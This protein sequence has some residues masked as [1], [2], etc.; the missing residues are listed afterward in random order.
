MLTQNRGGGESSTN[1]TAEQFGGLALYDIFCRGPKLDKQELVSICRDYYAGD[2]CYLKILD[3][4]TRDYKPSCA[5]WWYTKEPLIYSLL[6]KALRAFDRH[7]ISLF[8]FFIRDMRQALAK[9]HSTSGL[10]EPLRLYRGQTMQRDEITY[11]S[12]RVGEHVTMRAFLSTTDRMVAL[13][14]ASQPGNQPNAHLLEPVLLEI[15]ADPSMS[16]LTPFANIQSRSNHPDEEEWLFHLNPI[17]TL[18]DIE[19]NDDFT[20]PTVIRLTLTRI[21]EYLLTPLNQIA[22]VMGKESICSFSTG[23]VALTDYLH[24]TD[25]Q[26]QERKHFQALCEAEASAEKGMLFVKLGNEAFNNGHFALAIEC[27]RAAIHSPDYSLS[28]EVLKSSW[29]KIGYAHVQLEQID[30]AIDAYRRTLDICAFDE[31]YAESIWLATW[32]RRWL[33]I[34][35]TSQ[36]QCHEAI[37]LIRDNM[38]ITEVGGDNT[39]EFK[40]IDWQLCHLDR[41]VF[42]YSTFP[43]DQEWLFMVYNVLADAYTTLHEYSRARI[44]LQRALD[45]CRTNNITKKI[46]STQAKLGRFFFWPDTGWVLR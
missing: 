8:A 42:Y 45:I 1:P 22:K 26:V 13:M 20:K 23:L 21:P 17:F 43:D 36:N 9:L 27:Y 3:E 6:N 41:S 29:E 35:L 16:V 38:Q 31:S 15:E 28:D 19:R 39:K 12:K 37:K 40:D 30:P 14:F 34:L 5:L 44:S 33:A 18:T 10:K 11:L 7:L 2:T 4:F 32:C 24:V 46:K 25:R